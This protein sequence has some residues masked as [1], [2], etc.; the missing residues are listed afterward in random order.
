RTLPDHMLPTAFVS[1]AA[2]PLSPS[3][4][5]DRAALPEPEPDGAGSAAGSYSPPVSAT[6]TAVAQI[7]QA[8]L[9]V[10]RV[11]R[12]DDFFALA[13]HSLL[14][15]QVVARLRA[16]TEDSGHRV[17]V[18]DLFQH[19]SVR[20]LAELIDG[21]VARQAGQLLYELTTPVGDASRVCSYVCVPYG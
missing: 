11:G 5:L 14:A 8:V 21:K 9:G 19:R 15:A 6:E 16:L 18:M 17:G 13:G 20:Q 2:L 4:K 1:I 7:W 12:D 10:A 3:G